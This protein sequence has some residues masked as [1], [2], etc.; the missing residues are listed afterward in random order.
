MHQANAQEYGPVTCAHN[1]VQA[2]EQGK[3]L[4]H[5]RLRLGEAGM[6]RDAAIVI[7]AARHAAVMG[8]S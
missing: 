4:D 1:E 7:C 8:S 5:R 3:V 2:V 6:P